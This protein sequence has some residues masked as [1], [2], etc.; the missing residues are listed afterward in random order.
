MLKNGPQDYKGEK[1]EM[2]YDGHHLGYLLLFFMKIL[3]AK[4]RSK[5]IEEWLGI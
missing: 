3:M 5:E 1:R 2:L 4:A